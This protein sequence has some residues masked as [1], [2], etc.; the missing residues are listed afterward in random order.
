M[1]IP[2]IDLAEEWVRVED[3][4]DFPDD[5]LTDEILA[6]FASKQESLLRDF[7]KCSISQTLKGNDDVLSLA[8]SQALGQD[9]S[10]NTQEPPNPDGTTIMDPKAGSQEDSSVILIR[11]NVISSSQHLNAEETSRE[12]KDSREVYAKKSPPMETLEQQQQQHQQ[13]PRI[14]IEHQ[15][16]MEVVGD[17][18]DCTIVACIQAGQK[19]E[20]D[21]RL[22][23]V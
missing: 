2:L 11:S 4:F 16:P 1:A 13:Q 21:E 9:L 18:N 6:E 8:V 14:K 10:K 3:E 17:T 7:P 5:E 22:K 12:C 20:F 15:E 23:T 19:N